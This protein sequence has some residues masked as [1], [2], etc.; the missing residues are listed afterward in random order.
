LIE[1]GNV[2]QML[3]QVIAVVATLLYSG[4]AS[5]VILKVLDVIPGLGLRVSE[6]DEDQGLDISAHGERAFV[7]DGAD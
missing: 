2:D 1:G 4:I 5:L 7:T 3:T 6:T